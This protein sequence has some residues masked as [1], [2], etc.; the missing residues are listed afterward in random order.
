MQNLTITLIQTELHWEDVDANLNNMAE[1]ISSITSPTDLIILP[2]MFT[3]GFT[4]NPAYLAESP[5][6][7][8]HHWLKEIAQKSNASVLGSIIVCENDNYFNR[9]LVVSPE[10]TS[11]QYDKKHLFAYAG[12]DKAFTAGKERLIFQLKGWKICPMVCYDLRFPTWS[13]NHFDS[14]KKEA[15]YDLLLYVANWPKPRINAWDTLLSAR[16]IE[17]QT[18]VAGVNR[19]GID[20]NNNEYIGHSAV[21]DYAGYNVGNLE[22]KDGHISVMLSKEKQSDFRKALP[23]LRDGGGFNLLKV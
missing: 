5:N 1:I 10:G 12:E 19:I 2:E 4:M 14:I 7:K 8:T 17:N 13:K 6:G 23:F 18:Y 22:E 3:T 20:A 11:Y 15:D 16:A 9:L 21:Y